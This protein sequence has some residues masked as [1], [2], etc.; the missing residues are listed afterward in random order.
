[1]IDSEL[2]RHQSN[3]TARD[4]LGFLVV[5][6]LVDVPLLESLCT[7]QVWVEL[8]HGDMQASES[9]FRSLLYYQF[10]GK[11]MSMIPAK[12]YD[13]GSFSQFQNLRWSILHLVQPEEALDFAQEVFS[14]LRN[15]AR[16]LISFYIGVRFR[17]NG[18]LTPTGII[19]A[20]A[21]A[22]TMALLKMVQ[23]P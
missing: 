12:D 20:R 6:Y 15:S 7:H 13:V 5:Q 17:G 23:L 8:Q 2:H 3:C 14:E 1:M 22:Q 21:W 19:S 10:K 18:D 16:N 11:L 4:T 9:T